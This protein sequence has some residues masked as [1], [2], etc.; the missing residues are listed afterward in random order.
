MSNFT[1]EKHLEL[2]A[3]VSNLLAR[4][5]RDGGHYQQKHG[6]L[7]A[8]KDAEKKVCEMLEFMRPITEGF[9]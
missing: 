1:K 2:L 4:I 9:D 8:V 6:T 3:A 7:K 5:H